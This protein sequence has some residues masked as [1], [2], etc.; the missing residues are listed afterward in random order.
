MKKYF[1]LLLITFQI[2][3]FA[4]E[5]D[6]KTITDWSNTGSHFIIPATAKTVSII[7]FGAKADNVFDNSAALQNAIKS[8]N[9][10][11]GIINIP[12]G[13]YLFK[14]SI[15]I[16]SNILIKGAGSDK[17]ILNFNLNGNGD[18]FSIQGNLTTNS[19]P[20]SSGTNKDSKIINVANAA[21]FAIGDYCIVR[22]SADYLLYNNWSYNSFFQIIKIAS[23]DGNNITFENP[24]R[25]DFP[26]KNNPVLVKINP[27]Q[28]I[29]IESLKIKRLDGTS[30]NQTS[31]IFFNFAVNCWIKGVESELTNYAHFTLQS[32]ANI[33]VSGNYLHDAFDY[34]SG[35]KAYGVVLQF[36]SGDNFIYDNIAKHLRHSFLLQAQANGNVIAYNYSTDPFWKET[37]L[38]DNAAGDIVLHGNYP[39][40]NLFEGNIVQNIVIDNSHGAN[41]PFNTFFRNRIENYGLVMNGNAG[42]HMNSFANEI[43]GSGILKGLYGFTGDNVEIANNIKGNI[44]DGSIIETSLISKDYSA[45]I[46]PPNILNSW[47]NDAYNRYLKPI[48]TYSSVTYI[49]TKKET[50][51]QDTIAKPKPAVKPKTTVTKK[52]VTKKKTTVSKAPVKKPVAK[53]K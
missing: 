33:T 37:W 19:S 23:V 18:L 20:I 46:G 14:K 35:G 13:N 5:I 36:G 48:K 44:R 43:T 40:S 24:L 26:T 45:N 15:S 28:N 47:K 9:G 39:Y 17:T 16:P 4:T 53:K 29:G 25:L 30:S 49:E 11:F 31:N 38:H 8:F 21:N 10:N 6:K 7:D 12:T 51:K 22:Q 2:I 52:P 34:G 32:S 41:G 42:E 3:T 27:V 1:L 50:G